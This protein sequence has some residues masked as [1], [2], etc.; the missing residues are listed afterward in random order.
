MD[1]DH[2]KAKTPR[3]S[4][5]AGRSAWTQR[6]AR[7]DHKGQERR[8]A[9]ERSRIIAKKGQEERGWF[10]LASCMFASICFYFVFP[11]DGMT[12]ASLSSCLHLLTSETAGVHHHLAYVVKPR[13]FFVQVRQALCKLSHSLW[14]PDLYLHRPKSLQHPVSVSL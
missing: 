5:G 4:W 9:Q 11:Q 13:P 1:T 2:T 3:R 12:F 6:S 14:V 10:C 8:Q 7:E